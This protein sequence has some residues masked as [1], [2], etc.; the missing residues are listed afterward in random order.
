MTES[1]FACDQTTLKL[2]MLVMA[3]AFMLVIYG[4]HAGTYPRQAR[5]HYKWSARMIGVCYTPPQAWER[6]RPALFEL[7]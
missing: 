5:I 2:Q 6:Q 4:T 3:F 1:S 7:G